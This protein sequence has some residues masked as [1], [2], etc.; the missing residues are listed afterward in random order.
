VIICIFCGFIAAL[1]IATVFLSLIISLTDPVLEP[2]CERI[3]RQLSNNVSSSNW[4]VSSAAASIISQDENG[5][6]LIMPCE[7]IALDEVGNEYQ[8]DGSYKLVCNPPTTFKY[9]TSVVTWYTDHCCTP[10][11]WKYD[12]RTHGYSSS[13][14]AGCSLF[15]NNLCKSLVTC[16]TIP[17]ELEFCEW[18]ENFNRTLWI[19]GIPIN[20]AWAVN[21]SLETSPVSSVP[22]GFWRNDTSI[23]IRA[24]DWLFLEGTV[25]N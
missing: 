20:D 5:T 24:S 10:P 3:E 9:V 14:A 12:K 22:Y 18:I 11:K 16:E 4:G 25:F 8:I 7:G 21:M 23:F 15:C 17:I 2:Q 6:T 19:N 1:F 13:E